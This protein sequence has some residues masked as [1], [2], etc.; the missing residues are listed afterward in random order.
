MKGARNMREELKQYSAEARERIKAYAR[1]AADFGVSTERICNMLG[2]HYGV[3]LSWET[4]D[5]IIVIT[6]CTWTSKSGIK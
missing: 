1:A 3:D 4:V 2:N 6:G 5:M